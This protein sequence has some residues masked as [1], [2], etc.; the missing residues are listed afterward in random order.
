M[1]ELKPVVAIGDDIFDCLGRLPRKTHQRAAQFILKFRSN[2]RSPGINY[3]LIKNA[4]DQNLRS[5][6]ITGSLRGIVLAPER[7]NVYVLLWLDNHDEAYKWAVNRRARVNVASGSLQV[8]SVDDEILPKAEKVKTDEKGLFD[9]L[10]DRELIRIGVPEDLIVSVRSLKN[11]VDLENYEKNLPPEAYEGLYMKVAGFTYEEVMNELDRKD[12]DSNIQPDDFEAALQTDESKRKYW[13]ADNEKELEHMLDAPLEK[14]RVFLHP[15]QRKLVARD[16]NGPVRV[17]GGAGTGKTVVAMHRARWLAKNRFHQKNNKILFTTFTSNLAADIESNLKDICSDEEMAQIEVTNLDA[18]V[19]S[20][21]KSRGE[22]RKIVFSN[23]VNEFWSEAVNNYGSELNLEVK[24][25]QDEWSSVIQSN[26]IS[27]VGEYFKVARTGR[28]TRLDRRKRAEIWR[29]F[30]A[31]RARLDEEGFIEP[32]D[33][34]RLAR[35][36]LTIKPHVLPYRAVVVDE[37]QDMGQEAFK[38]LRSIVPTPDKENLDKNS[39]FIVGD[40]HQRIYGRRVILGRCGVNII[41]RGRKLRINYRTSD[42]IRKWAVSILEN[43]EIDD[44]DDG[45]DNNKGY[46]SLFH[47]PEPMI[48]E[49]ANTG[50][51]IDAIE[52]WVKQLVSDGLTENDICLIAR[53]GKTITDYKGAFETKGYET[54]QLKRRVADNRQKEGLRFA[55]MHRA[56]GLEFI[57]VALVAMNEKLIPHPM[58]LR[59]APD[60]AG[61]EEVFDAERMLVYVA[62]TRAKKMLLISSSGGLTSLLKN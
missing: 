36:I 51:A 30:E 6:R 52:K 34:Y 40:G 13:V 46:H 20:F 9:D 16:W 35:E 10:R 37:A 5:V 28:G 54:V 62:A 33:A 38:L 3:E 15:S 22:S 58:A 25:F 45:S 32:D 26:S 48:I 44:L 56:K 31:Y 8:F 42:E 12:E 50:A 1:S 39:M 21:L 53:D 57:A 23:E 43:V 49:S 27:T 11:D 59:A 17:L 19:Y 41:G 18:W 55:T 47:G 2:P 24:F 7:G 29:V 60:E 14:W 4:V 61:R